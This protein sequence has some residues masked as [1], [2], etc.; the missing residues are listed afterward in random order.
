MNTFSRIKIYK[1]FILIR[2]KFNFSTKEKEPDDMKA[3]YDAIKNKLEKIREEENPNPKNLIK[4]WNFKNTIAWT[5]SSFILYYHG[6]IKFN[7]EYN[8]FSGLFFIGA[9]I[10]YYKDSKL[11]MIFYVMIDQFFSLTRNKKIFFG[12]E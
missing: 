8:F 5:L 12:Y 7:K 3:F 4:I 9:L 10:K 6:K 1:K 11:D 2:N